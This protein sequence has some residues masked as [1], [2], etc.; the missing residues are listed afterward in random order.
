MHWTYFTGTTLSVDILSTLR[1][2]YL[3]LSINMAMLIVT[4]CRTVSRQPHG[5]SFAMTSLTLRCLFN[6]FCVDAHF[7][8]RSLL[9]PELNLFDS[10]LAQIG[11]K[12]S[13]GEI[14]E[15]NS[16]NSKG[17]IEL[18]V[19]QTI[20]KKSETF[21]VSTIC[22]TTFQGILALANRFSLENKRFQVPKS[23]RVDRSS[24]FSRSQFVRVS[25]AKRWYWFDIHLICTH[26]MCHHCT[27]PASLTHIVMFSLQTIFGLEWHLEWQD[28]AFE[29]QFPSSGHFTSSLVKFFQTWKQCIDEIFWHLHSQ[30]PVGRISFEIWK[31]HQEKIV[32]SLQKEMAGKRERTLPNPS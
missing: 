15:P 28:S 11:K 10:W 30:S 21:E 5:E 22:V 13:L 17:Q 12:K 2:R 7:F 26:F 9:G 23:S 8:A 4:Q 16:A 29:P 6:C 27:V 31:G 25:K 18:L 32:N 3:S 19:Q 20:T 14:S 24:L 1:I